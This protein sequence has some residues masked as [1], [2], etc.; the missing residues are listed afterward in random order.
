MKL[1]QLKNIIKE[2]LRKLR[3]KRSLNENSIKVICKCDDYGKTCEGTMSGLAADCSC[4]DPDPR[5]IGIDVPHRRE[6]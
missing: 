5:G 2:E 1:N 4:C 6:R 3:T